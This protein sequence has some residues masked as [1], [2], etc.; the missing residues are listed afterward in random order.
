MFN[1]MD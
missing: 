1:D